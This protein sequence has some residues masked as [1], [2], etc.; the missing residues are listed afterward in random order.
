MCGEHAQETPSGS[1]FHVRADIVA[2]YCCNVVAASGE[3]ARARLEQTFHHFLNGM[4]IGDGEL[5]IDLVETYN[6]FVVANA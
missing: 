6:R 5:S 2:A 1:T 3:E 4:D